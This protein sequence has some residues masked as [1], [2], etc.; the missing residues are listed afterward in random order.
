MVIITGASGQLGQL[1]T[2]RL[3]Q[4][5]AI[6]VAGTHGKSLE[7][8]A[9]RH[10]D[11]DQPATLDFR[12]VQT[13]LLISAGYGEDDEVIA[14]HA[15]VIDAAERDGVR[16]VVYTS[17]TGR[18]DHLAFALAHRWTERRLQRSSLQWTILRNGLYVELIRDLTRAHDGVVTA[19]LGTGK[20]AWVARADLADAAANVMLNPTIHA[21]KIYELVGDVA[22]SGQDLAEQQGARYQPVTLAQTRVALDRAAL[23]PF[24]PPMLMS[25]YSTI[26]GVFL[27][28]TESDLPG[29]LQLKPGL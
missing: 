8:M 20:V 2:A 21:R 7:N 18:G 27:E 22:V 5:R 12:G 29:L 15:N 17:L 6:F 9:S 28:D 26:A 14:R 10:I 1:V 11:F 25:I 3:Q 19:P 16:Q 23:L 13:L 4:H 24:Q